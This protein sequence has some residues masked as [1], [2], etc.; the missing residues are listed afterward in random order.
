MSA[1]EQFV[2]ILVRSG[3]TGQRPTN[4][5]CLDKFRVSVEVGG[6]VPQS[7]AR[8]AR[9]ATNLETAE[10][11]RNTYMICKAKVADILHAHPLSGRYGCHF[12]SHVHE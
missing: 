1:Q 3:A 5:Q 10:S 9:T 6:L 12:L 8:R 4:D 2:I 11:K 7:A